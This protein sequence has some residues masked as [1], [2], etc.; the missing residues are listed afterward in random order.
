M[1]STATLVDA[2]FHPVPLVYVW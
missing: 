1:Q 2:G